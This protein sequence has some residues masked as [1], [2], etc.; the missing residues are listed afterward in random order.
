MLLQQNN[1]KGEIS[2]KL[3]G[4]HKM[5]RAKKTIQIDAPDSQG[6]S[7]SRQPPSTHPVMGVAWG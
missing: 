7:N 1:I 4:Q 6:G 5:A 2:E 3:N